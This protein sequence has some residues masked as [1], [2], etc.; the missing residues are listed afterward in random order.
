MLAFAAVVDARRLHLDHA[1]ARPHLPLF[2][3][4]VAHGQAFARLVD[5]V[6]V[7]VQVRLALD[8]QRRSEHQPRAA[9]DQGLTAWFSVE[10]LGAPVRRHRVDDT[11]YKAFT[12]LAGAQ[13]TVTDDIGLLPI[14]ADA[15]EGL[16]R[17]VDAAYEKRSLA[18]S[19]NI[20]PSGFDR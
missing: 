13:L 8:Q 6:N 20:H 19:T 5:D 4:A 11:V 14:S 9:V 12:A 15:S 3:V 18:L 2:G 16:Y 1:G 7:G 17:L 10:D